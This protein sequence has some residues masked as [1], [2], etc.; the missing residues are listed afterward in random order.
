M[1]HDPD[2]TDAP[3]ALKRSVSLPMLVLYGL[4]VTV[5][6]GIYVLVGSAAV[7]AGAHT[8]LAFVLAAIITGLSAASFA[9]LAQRLPVAAGEAA[10]VRAAFRSSWLTIMVGCLVVAAGTVSA[11]AIS[12]G[13]AGYIG[14]FL[15]IE[16]T[17]IIAIV[18]LAMGAVAAFGIDEAVGLASLMTLIELSGL[19]VIVVAGVWHDPAMLVRAPEIVAGL[20]DPAAWRGVLSASILAFFAFIGFEGMVN[21]VE[22]VENPRHTLP[23][24]IAL[25]LAIA[26]VLYVVVAWVALQAVPHHELAATSAPLSLVFTRLT[27]ASPTFISIIAIFATINGIIAQIVMASRVLYGLA[28]QGALPAALARINPMTRTPLLAT[29]VV[30]IGAVLL[31]TLLPIDRLAEWTSRVMLLIF[32]LVDAALVAIKLRDGDAPETLAVPVAVPAA[33]V[34]SSLLLLVVSF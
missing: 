5:G 34:V 26:T 27:G 31:A 18:L 3:S 13:A 32:A 10:Y 23:L 17:V 8:P 29:A 14:V 7:R 12:R 19:V 25:T 4:G 11:A 30:V 2:T 22:E 9:E 24:A 21:I 15:P 1:Q 16:P 33:G 20:D 6:A 28:R